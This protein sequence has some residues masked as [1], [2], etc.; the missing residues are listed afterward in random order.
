M[1]VGLHMSTELKQAQEQTAG[2][3]TVAVA[4]VIPVAVVEV[5]PVEVVV[6]SQHMSGSLCLRRR[7]SHVKFFQEKKSVSTRYRLCIKSSSF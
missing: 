3:L 7:Q 5:A 4:A 2:I 6:V 1:R